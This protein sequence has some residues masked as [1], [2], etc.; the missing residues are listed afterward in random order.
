MI[1]SLNQ[2]DL[3]KRYTVKDYMSWRFRERVELIRG[4]IHKMSPAPGRR[5]QAISRELLIEIGLFLRGYACQVFDAPFDVQLSKKDES[6]VVQ[7]DL[8]VVC[9]ESKLTEQG[10]SGAPDII[11]EILSPGNS[12]R[13]KKEK[14][15]LYEENGVR[16]YW[17][18]E[19]LSNT[20]YPY[21][22]DSEGVF[23]GQKPLVI[24]EQLTS[25]VL[26]GL[27]IDLEVIFKD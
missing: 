1:T 20:I 27:E 3:T 17:I 11:I 12:S 6:T 23:Q 7:P 5:H 4:I 8:C 2:L 22:L 9:D 10:C 24:G 15:E 13:E 21:I 16:E 25:T 14:Y 26:P 18:V 19:P